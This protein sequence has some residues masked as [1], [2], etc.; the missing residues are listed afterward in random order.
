MSIEPALVILSNGQT[1]GVGTVDTSTN[2]LS[3]G[4]PRQ[5]AGLNPGGTLTSLNTDDSGNLLVNVAV[6]G[7]V[8]GGGSSSGTVAV[9]GGT[10]SLT[11][12]SAVTQAPLLASGISAVSGTFTGAGSSAPFVAPAG[13]SFNVAV[14][15]A[16][17]NAPAPGTSLGGTVYLARSTDGGTTTLP[18]TGDGTQLESFTTV[19]SESWTE[20]QVGVSYEL[21]CT[22]TPTNPI[23]YRISA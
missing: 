14:W 6:G 19:A 21:V 22:G 23:A 1:W 2:I 17:N 10:V 13:R 12:T 8:G 18:L 20:S 7:G 5:V 15:P 16:G 3:F 11:G 9:S 4:Q